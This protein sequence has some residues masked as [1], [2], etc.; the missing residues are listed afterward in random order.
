V[1]ADSKSGD[2]DDESAD[3]DGAAEGD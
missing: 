2:E 1:P 3:I